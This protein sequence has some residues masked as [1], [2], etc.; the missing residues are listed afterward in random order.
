[1]FPESMAEQ[2]YSDCIF[3]SEMKETV[4]VQLTK[5]AKSRNWI[6]YQR[7]GV[8]LSICLSSVKKNNQS[9]L[10]LQLRQEDDWT[11]RQTND[12]Q[13][14]APHSKQ[15]VKAPLKKFTQLC[16]LDL[17]GNVYVTANLCENVVQI[18]IRQY[19]KGN[20]KPY[21]TKKG[22][23]MSLME[24]S[25]LENFLNGMEEA[26]KN[27]ST[28][29]IDETWYLGSNLYAT[30]SKKYPLLDLRH[31]WKPN[32]NGNMLPTTKGVK[33]NRR[34][35]ENLKKCNFSHSRVHSPGFCRVSMPSIISDW[36]AIFGRTS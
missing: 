35:L 7:G 13:S 12:S 6:F 26:V 1:M 22:I 3:T 30:A 4:L 36:Y 33:L 27:Y 17:E 15:N 23:V 16:M 9:H 20:S 34:K 29:Q 24:W 32:P 2:L 28:R 8:R 10:A 5:F 31:Y 14:P 25:M 21:P 18:H 11:L 19:E